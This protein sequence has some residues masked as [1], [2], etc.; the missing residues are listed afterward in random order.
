MGKQKMSDGG[1]GVEKSPQVKENFC[2]NYVRSCGKGKQ[3]SSY[4]GQTRDAEQKGIK[5]SL[6][7]Y[8]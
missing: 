8:T 4:L 7:I 6:I 1:K 5:K 3:N 2:Q